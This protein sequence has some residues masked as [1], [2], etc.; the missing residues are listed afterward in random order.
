LSRTRSLTF[1]GPHPCNYS[2]RRGPL[3]PITSTSLPHN[4]SVAS[5]PIW[6]QSRSMRHVH[7]GCHHLRRGISAP[8]P[9]G[10][11][12][13]GVLG[14]ARLRLDWGTMGK[15]W[16]GRCN[17]LGVQTATLLGMSAAGDVQLSE[18]CL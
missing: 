15:V 9:G 8:A 7:N 11:P 17:G 14:C 5:R 13:A 18:R 1:D 6:T 4:E 10:P 16:Q 2:R 12:P 3:R